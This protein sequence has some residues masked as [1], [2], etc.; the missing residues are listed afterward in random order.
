MFTEDLM[1]WHEK[2]AR[3]LIWCGERDP[4]RIWISE[5][6]LQQ[7]RTETVTGYYRRFLAAFPT[8]Q[9]LAGADLQQVLKQWEGLGYYSRARN[10]HAAARLI[11]EKYGGV[12]PRDPEALRALPGI[13]DYTAGA[14]ASIAYGVRAP[15]VDGNLNRV[16]ARVLCEPRNVHSSAAKRAIYQA[17]FDRM[18]PDRPGDFNQALMGLGNL[19]CTP[20]HP[21][22]DRCPVRADCLAFQTGTQTDYPVLPPKTRQRVERRA[23]ALVQC[24]EKVLLRRRPESALL[25]GLWE[26]PGFSEAVGREA[27]DE[28]LEELGLGEARYA[29][30]YGGARHVFS[31]LIW[32]MTGYL[33]RLDREILP[34]GDYRFATREELDALPLATA[35]R[36]F[37]EA[38]MQGAP[39][40]GRASARARKGP[41]GKPSGGGR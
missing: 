23:V 16:M 19:V 30:M 17:V 8:V 20:L 2:N 34:E 10:L 18:P 14:I 32:E 3:S 31:H 27:V 9:A 7:T 1:A 36:F 41:S 24:G 13:G 35:L 39:P 5:I 38:W 26:F 12:L 6:M 22:C 28:C 21:A 40:A 33:Y 37:R 29:G 11:V 15:A 4:Y 25:G